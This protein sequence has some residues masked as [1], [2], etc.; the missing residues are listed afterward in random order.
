MLIFSENSLTDGGLVDVPL[1]ALTRGGAG[2]SGVGSEGST[3]FT[4]IFSSSETGMRA[5]TLR[6]S[7][8][9]FLVL[10]T[11]IRWVYDTHVV[12]ERIPEVEVDE[13]GG[14]MVRRI[15]GSSL[16]KGNSCQDEYIVQEREAVPQCTC[17]TSLW[18]RQRNLRLG[19]EASI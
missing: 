4:L 1:E 6:Y 3:S 12:F 16:S 2:E 7:I 9:A 13:V 11:E 14:G 5:R 8:F 15:E 17:E 10:F 18:A 19:H